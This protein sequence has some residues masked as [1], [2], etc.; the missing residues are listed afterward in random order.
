ME[1]DYRL[2][3][4]KMV[5]TLILKTESQATKILSKYKSI[6]I[7]ASLLSMYYV[8]GIGLTF[9]IL[10][11]FGIYNLRG[12]SVTFPFHMRKLRL[13]GVSVTVPKIACK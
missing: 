7:T 11:S 3:E 13:Q 5:R 12:Q 6:L 4:P 8:P 9:Y 1:R 10:I 2:S